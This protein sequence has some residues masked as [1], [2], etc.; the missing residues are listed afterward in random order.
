MNYGV[1]DI[2]RWK[3]EDV[4]MP[5]HWIEH[6][7]EI[8]HPFRMYVSG[9]GGHGKTEYLMQ[10]S[11]MFANHLGKVHLN[12]LEQGKHKS[13]QQSWARNNFKGEVPA[14]KW[15]YGKGLTKWED[16]LAYLTK[17]NSCQIAIIDSISYWELTYAQ[18][19]HLFKTFPNKSF[20]TVGYGAHW[21]AHRAIRHLHDTKVKVENFEAIVLSRYG[22]M[23]PHIIFQE[24]YDKARRR[25]SPSRGSGGTQKSI[26]D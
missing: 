21:G 8:P 9:E 2:E 17:R 1:N 6:L 14:G 23:K 12:N 10:L 16:Y 4:D 24:G 25:I 26:F 15:M 5:Q 22:G 11:K 13:I 3:F 20:I 7:G 18:L 19:K